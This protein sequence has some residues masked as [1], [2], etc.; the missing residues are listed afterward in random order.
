[1][2]S[3]S[4]SLMTRLMDNEDF[5]EVV[6]RPNATAMVRH[7]PCI[8]LDLKPAGIKV[9]RAGIQQLELISGADIE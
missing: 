9:T 7:S 5:Q 3:I 2:T 4:K 6:I 8:S 1:M